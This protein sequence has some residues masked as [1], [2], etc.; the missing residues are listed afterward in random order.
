MK[1]IGIRT[2]LTITLLAGLTLTM[3]LYGWFRIHQEKK[4][5]I[6]ETQMKVAV[7]AK[8]I[9]IAVENALRDRQ[10]QDIRNLTAELVEYQTEIDRIRLF[11]DRLRLIITSNPLKI[12]E[13]V[14]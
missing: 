7:T 5:L 8:A 10:I 4:Q 12:G 11:D 3:G 6:E 9:Q 13:E 2:R 14:P 1:T